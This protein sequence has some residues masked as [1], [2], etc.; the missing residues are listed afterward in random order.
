MNEKKAKEEIFINI[1]NN[2]KD[3]LLSVEIL[4]CR[5]KN[6]NE[7]HAAIF[8]DVKINIKFNIL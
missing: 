7:L 8:I 1:R 4:S 6:K 2:F 3:G 5:K